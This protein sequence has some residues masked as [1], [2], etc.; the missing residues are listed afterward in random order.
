MYLNST[1]NIDYLIIVIKLQFAETVLNYIST[2]CFAKQQYES[3]TCFLYLFCTIKSL[4]ASEF[5]IARQKEKLN[6]HL[7][8]WNFS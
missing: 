7:K 3:H 8:K 4:K 2:K 5:Y 1:Q 6:E